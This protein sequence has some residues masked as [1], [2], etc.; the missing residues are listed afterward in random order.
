MFS[1]FKA[2]V[3]LFQALPDNELTHKKDVHWKTF[4][5]ST[6]LSRCLKYITSYRLS[7]SIIYSLL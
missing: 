3:I 5:V 6:F 4:T 2:F 7:L 1:S